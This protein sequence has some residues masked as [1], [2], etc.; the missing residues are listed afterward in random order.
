MCVHVCVHVCACVCACVGVCACVCL[1]GETAAEMFCIE[2]LL[3]MKVMMVLELLS[4]GNLK[5]H[6]A[7]LRPEQVHPSHAPIF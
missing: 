7:T 4:K 1:G 6:L 2:T 3:A 5:A